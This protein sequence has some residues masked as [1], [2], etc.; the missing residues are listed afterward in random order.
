MTGKERHDEYHE[1]RLARLYREQGDIEPGPGVDQRIRAHARDKAHPARV[2]RPAQWLGGAAVAASLF[3]VVSV[4]VNID[5]PRPDL[6]QS[7]IQAESGSAPMRD[8]DRSEASSFSAEPSR[9]S[10]DEAE[11]PAVLERA[12]P[13]L[14]A[15]ASAPVMQRRERQSAA[16]DAARTAQEQY[17]ALGA[18]GQNEA[19]RADA[20]EMLR[21]GEEAEREVLA[22]GLTGPEASLWL[23]ER[24]ISV[25]NAER[26]RAEVEAFRESYPEREI[27]PR[28]LSRL[29]EL[30]AAGE[31]D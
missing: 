30:E 21:P 4:V 10:V 17:E 11:P 13:M 9:L 1:Q 18:S 25:G 26:A 24:L 3:I 14:S 8:A 27:P 5:P 23:I 22:E 16:D 6:P 19:G 12:A 29:E 15:P 7:D 31:S 20:R 28:L 2:P